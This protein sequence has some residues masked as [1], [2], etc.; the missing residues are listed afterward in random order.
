MSHEGEKIE[1]N[2][3]DGTK[4]PGYV[5]GAKAAPGVR[6]CVE[7]CGTLTQIF[8][9]TGYSGARMVGCGLGHQIACELNAPSFVSQSSFARRPHKSL[10]RGIE[11]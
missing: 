2:R 7:R 5:Y 10:R 11:R 1:F 6:L 3:E 4:V 8:R 9:C